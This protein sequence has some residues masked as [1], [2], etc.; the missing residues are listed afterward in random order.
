MQVDAS[1]SITSNNGL[2]SL[3]GLQN[4]VTLQG[5]LN[6]ANNNKLINL[7]GLRGMTRILGN[8]SV[9][10]NGSLTALEGLHNL[11]R[12][13]G[14]LTISSN[15][16]IADLN[17]LRRLREINWWSKISNNQS[18][19]SLKGLERLKIAED[20]LEITGNPALTS[21]SELAQLKTA[22]QITITN[23]P[24]LSDCA[25]KIVCERIAYGSA[26][27]SGN[28]AGCAN[29]EEVRLTATCSPQT[30]VRINAGGPDFTT[31]T[32]KLFV[33]DQYYA[34]IDRTSSIASGDILNTTNDVLYRSARSAS[35]FSYNIPVVNELVNVTLHFAETYFGVPGTKGEKGGP[36][37]RRFHVNIEGSRKLTNYDIFTEAGGALRANQLTIPVTVT[38]GILNIDFLT[39][40]ADI[41]RVSAIEVTASPTLIPVE[42]GMV[43]SGSNTNYVD[44]DNLYVREGPYR[45]YPTLPWHSYFKFQLPAGKAEIT[46]AKLRVYGHNND[47][48]GDNTDN[49]PNTEIHVYGVNDDSWTEKAI[50]GANAPAASLPSLG[51]VGV[52]DVLKYYEIDVTNYVNAQRQSG[53]QIISLMLG[54]P[55]NQSTAVTF[56]SKEGGFYPPQ[57]IYQTTKIFQPTNMTARIGQEEVFPEAQ[58]RQQ[59]TVYPNPIQDQFTVSVSPEHTGPISF[60]MINTAGKSH[61]IPAP[62]NAKPGENTE[63]NIAGQSF[64]TGIYLLK[65]KSDAFTEAIK[66]LVA[67]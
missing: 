22:S 2:L 24:L 63:L 14:S 12:V 13:R 49:N 62:Q 1:I 5:S 46:S 42:D 43:A 39:G 44:S 64:H 17:G 11:S 38:D 47:V 48:Y 29:T 9:G 51:S 15:G 32:Q 56:S 52:N 27:I 65:V 67:E 4:L 10:S 40:A 50:T 18:L 57:L 41:P 36:G 58:K 34:G 8:L 35:S 60:E 6:I 7:N 53:D 30:L 31:A 54:N 25:I 16:K 33:A 37:S 21:I 59:S 45:D 3:E 20:E 55:A 23:N 26:T 66:V 19:K 61:F 28:A